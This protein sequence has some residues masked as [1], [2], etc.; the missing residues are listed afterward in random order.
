MLGAEAASLPSIGIALDAMQISHS[1]IEEPEDT[2]HIVTTIDN[3]YQNSTP[4][5]FLIGRSPQA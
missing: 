3:A 5:C 4:H 1:L 2:K